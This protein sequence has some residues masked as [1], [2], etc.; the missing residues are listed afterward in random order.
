[1]GIIALLGLKSPF[2]VVS[3][4]TESSCVFLDIKKI[5]IGNCSIYVHIYPLNSIFPKFWTLTVQDPS[6]REYFSLRILHS[7]CVHMRKVFKHLRKMRG[8]YLSTYGECGKYLSVD[9]EYVNQGY[10]RYTK[11]SPYAQK[12]LNVFENA[13]KGF[14]RTWRRRKKALGVFS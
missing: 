10:L 2:S 5:K 3:V 11:S 13:Q 9:G 12:V 4:Y 8:K 1:M 7:F 14:M 6:N